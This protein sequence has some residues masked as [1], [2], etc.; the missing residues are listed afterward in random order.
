M[1]TAHRQAGPLP[2]LAA[3]PVLRGHLGKPFTD[4]LWN[5]WLIDEI[6]IPA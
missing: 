5:R 4:S 6:D 2:I 1:S 3:G